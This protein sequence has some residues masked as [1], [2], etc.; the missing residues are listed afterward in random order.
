[1]N[2]YDAVPPENDYATAFQ[3]QHYGAWG[4]MEWHT[5]AHIE[6]AE[7][8]ARPNTRWPVRSIATSISKNQVVCV[9]SRMQGT[10]SCDRV[11]RTNTSQGSSKRLVAMRN[12]RTVG[13]DSG[14]PWSYSDRA[15][16]IHKGWKRIWFKR[17]NT[18][19]RVS[20][21]GPALNVVVRTQ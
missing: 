8:Y 11:Y 7:Y 5:T 4:D 19:S 15:F 16:G 18:W 20:Y 1:M 2:W 6:P 10:R 17:R 21:L 13:G 12:H 3:S 9:F 14:G